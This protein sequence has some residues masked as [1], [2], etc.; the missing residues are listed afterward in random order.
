VKTIEIIVSPKGETKLETKGFAGDSCRQ[1]SAFLELAL[2]VKQLDQPSAEA[3]TAT[4]H[5]MVRQSP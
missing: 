2:G 1:A 3:F 4:D 5:S